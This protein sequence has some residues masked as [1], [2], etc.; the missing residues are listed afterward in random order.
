M[1]T[2]IFRTTIYQRIEKLRVRTVAVFVVALLIMGCA[3][4]ML[5][6]H[7]NFFVY[8]AFLLVMLAFEIYVIKMM[9]TRIKRIFKTINADHDMEV[10]GAYS[11]I[12][13]AETSPWF[14]VVECI[15]VSF[16]MVTICVLK[17]VDTTLTGLYGLFLGTLVFVLGVSAYY[18]YI[19][20]A[21]FVYD[22]RNLKIEK[23][24]F[25][26]PALTEWFVQIANTLSFI[27]KWF[28]VL[29][30]M[31][32]TLYAIIMPPGI[33][34]FQNGIVI[35]SS[36]NVLFYTTWVG[37]LVFFVLAFPIITVLFRAFLKHIILLCKGQSIKQMER[38]IRLIEKSDDAAK[39]ELIERH[40]SLIK[41]ID[42]SSDYPLRYRRTVFDGAYSILMTIGAIA[43]PYI[44]LIEQFMFKGNP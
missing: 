36:N 30:M 25:Y 34:S 17:C 41:T 20:F 22:L 27:D 44:S 42:E 31:Y 35:S 40:I 6:P 5:M 23:Y 39:L 33:V 9:S 15:A 37:V 16:Y 1:K 29:G 7:R 4:N 14:Y 2:K 13:R 28:F 21:R 19:V 3:T 11:K 32:T 43:T 8:Q 24:N 26:M 18:R 38:C 10:L 12:S